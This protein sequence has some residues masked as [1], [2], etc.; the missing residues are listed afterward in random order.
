MLR[1][2]LSPLIILPVDG[3]EIELMGSSESRLWVPVRSAE[4]FSC[5]SQMAAQLPGCVYRSLMKPF[6]SWCQ[7]WNAPDWSFLL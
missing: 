2:A 4:R 5:F 1:R 7:E 6:E 3:E